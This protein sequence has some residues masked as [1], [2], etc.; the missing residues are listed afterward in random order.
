[1]NRNYF[2]VVL[3]YERLD[4]EVISKR[5]SNGARCIKI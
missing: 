1:M 2:K 5:S 3:L 4:I